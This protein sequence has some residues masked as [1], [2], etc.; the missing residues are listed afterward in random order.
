MA[1]SDRP[2]RPQSAPFAI[3]TLIRLSV[4]VGAGLVVANCGQVAQQAGGGIDPKY[5]V[6]ASPRVVKDGEPVPKGGGRQMVG[7][8]YTVAG[9]TYVPREN[10][11]YAAEGL[12]SWYGAAFHGRLTANGEVFDRESIAAA[13][14]T[15]PLP[16]YARVTNLRNK[17]SM[18]V[19]INDRGPFHA[20][21]VIDLS[22]RAAQALDFH[23][24]GTARVKVE[25]MGRAST[26]GSD[27]RKLLATLTTDGNPATFPGA[28]TTQFAGLSTSPPPSGTTSR[29]PAT[30]TATALA[31]AEPIAVPALS[32]VTPRSTAARVELASTSAEIPASAASAATADLV[33][34]L[35]TIPH[36]AVPTAL[37]VP[38][39]TPTRSQV[40]GLFYAPPNA[41][42]GVFAGTT[43]APGSAFA[44]LRP[45]GFSTPR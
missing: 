28:A 33:F 22:E 16:S 14:P 36:A 44:D 34:D 23:R 13:H 8:P 6:A 41:Y 9:K 40:A 2:L 3:R 21:R 1:G 20:G 42:P 15:M 25:Y 35:M 11:R 4:A 27:D 29:A 38:P 17:R 32:P 7:K 24:A 5:G 18:I 10:P 39:V 12:A 37:A 43:T 31:A 30:A 26:R 45:M 19:R